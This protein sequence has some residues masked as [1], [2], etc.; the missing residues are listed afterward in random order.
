MTLRNELIL[1][2]PRGR[3]R[4]IN[5]V[6]GRLNGAG[7]AL[8]GMRSEDH[9]RIRGSRPVAQMDRGE[10]RASPLGD[11]RPAVRR[12][13]RDRRVGGLGGEFPD[14]AIGVGGHAVGRLDHQALQRPAIG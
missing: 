5:E 7:P 10:S 4:A 8:A 9:A 6:P 1:S 2:R 14:Q 11:D 3:T 12:L 13:R